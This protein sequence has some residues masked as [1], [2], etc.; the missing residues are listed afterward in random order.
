VKKVIFLVKEVNEIYLNSFDLNAFYRQGIAV[1]FWIYKYL[2]RLNSEKKPILPEIENITVRSIFKDQLKEEIAKIRDTVFVT[3]FPLEYKYRFFFILLKKFNIEYIVLINRVYAIH[4]LAGEIRALNTKSGILNLIKSFTI[5]PLFR[6][7]NKYSFRMQKPLISV[8]GTRNNLIAYNFPPPKYGFKFF[9][10][11]NYETFTRANPKVKDEKVIVFIDQ[12]LPWHH[13]T[14]VFNK[15]KMNAESYYNKIAIT[16]KKIAEIKDCKV[17]IATHPKA[18]VGKI[19]PYVDGIPVYYG[20]TLSQVAKS[21]LVV[22][23]TSLSLDYFI[24]SNKPFILFICSEIKDSPIE[25]GVLIHAHEF[26]KPILYF[27]EHMDDLTNEKL[28][29]F[30]EVNSNNYSKYFTTNIKEN[31]SEQISYW[32]YIASFISN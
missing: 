8:L 5:T 14:Q 11:E 26:E 7:W 17:A 30:C 10:S 28:N 18:E 4:K 2:T 23:H 6:F 22:M 29:L 15:W 1:E 9:H 16:L 20:D 3:V 12:F 24:L 31:N 21:T 25:K 13:E 32:E 27:E 19:E